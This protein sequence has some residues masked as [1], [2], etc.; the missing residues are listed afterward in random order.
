MRVAALPLASSPLAFAPSRR[1]SSTRSCPSRNVAPASAGLLLT[2]SLLPKRTVLFSHHPRAVVDSNHLSIAA[3]S[4]SNP[5]CRAVAMAAADGGNSADGSK[6]SVL[7]VCLGNICRSPSAEGVFTHMVKQR[8][9]ADRF[10][11]DSAGTI[12]YHEGN[13]ADPRMRKAA[14]RRGI[15]LTSLSRPIRP[16]DFSTFD[17]ILA[18][19]RSNQDDI[20][21][22]FRQWQR[23]H[24][25][26]RDGLDKVKLMCSYCRKLNYDEVPDPYYGGAQGFETVLDLLDDACGG[27]LDSL[28]NE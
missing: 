8:G 12:D 20:G 9:L 5:S 14:E 10:H 3:R 1:A 7:F 16:S 18:M 19:D 4:L 22:A 15:P 2:S 23:P 21:R 26:P 25:L 24:D 28:I 6:I 17:I 13:P 27:L 11:V